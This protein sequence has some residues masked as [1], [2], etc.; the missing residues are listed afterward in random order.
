MAKTQKKIFCFFSE[1]NG[2]RPRA[3]SGRH[4]SAAFD[5]YSQSYLYSYICISVV[6]EAIFLRNLQWETPIKN[7]FLGPDS[8]FLGKIYRDFLSK[9]QKKNRKP[10]FFTKI[11]SFFTKFF[12]PFLIFMSPNTNTNPYPRLIFRIDVRVRVNGQG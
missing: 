4:N 9:F 2:F 3:A 1:K 8:V 5:I 10:R 6:T 12:F 7:L 11:I